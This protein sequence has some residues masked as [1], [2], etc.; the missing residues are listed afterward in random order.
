GSAPHRPETMAET[1]TRSALPA[2]S[3]QPDKVVGESKTLWTFDC[4]PRF[5]ATSCS[6]LGRFS[7]AS[8]RRLR[9]MSNR[10][11]WGNGVCEHEDWSTWKV[12]ASHTRT[13]PR[14]RCRGLC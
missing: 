12:D 11:W 2:A 4:L 9:R 8:L 14:S 1:R 3:V 13:P 6:E 7:K 5:S 10:E